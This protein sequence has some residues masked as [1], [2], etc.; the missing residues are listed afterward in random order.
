MHVIVCLDDKNGMTF[1]K[2][3]QSRDRAVI[4]DIISSLNGKE[5]YISD[6]SSI[7]FN[8]TNIHISIF[9]NFLSSP[10]KNGVYFIENEPVN[11][12]ISEIDSITVYRWNRIYPNDRTFDIDLTAPLW[13]LI[14]THDFEGTS[15]DKI[16]KEVYIKNEN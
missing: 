4:A 13:T 10:V 5:L 16:T 3:R 9:K 12:F 2:R 1:N 11:N 8:N 7:L 15:H 14:S 6:F